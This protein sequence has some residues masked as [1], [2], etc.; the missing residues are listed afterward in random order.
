MEISRNCQVV[1][2]YKWKSQE[3]PK[4]TAGKTLYTSPVPYTGHPQ[5]EYW[6]RQT[7]SHSI[8]PFFWASNATLSSR[9]CRKFETMAEKYCLHSPDS[10]TGLSTKKP[11]DVWKK[12]EFIISILLFQFISF[13]GNRERQTSKNACNTGS[14]NKK[15]TENVNHWTHTFT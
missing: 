6:A 8:Q 4:Q 14:N 10:S 5:T 3:I 7:L 13:K 1:F 12:M 2:K 15:S 11:H 9:A